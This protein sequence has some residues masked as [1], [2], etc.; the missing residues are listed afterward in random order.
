MRLAFFLFEFCVG[1]AAAITA[2]FAAL[3]LANFN[4]EAPYLLLLIGIIGAA[5]IGGQAAG[6]VALVVSMLLVWF[7]FIPP[8]WSFALPSWR[9]AATLLLFLA[10]AGCT[11]WLYHREKR[12]IDELSDANAALR[13]KQARQL[14]G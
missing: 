1:I 6:I 3:E 9:Y 11:C 10:A 4:I 5:V 8:V 14:R 12:R 2:T 13:A 7:F